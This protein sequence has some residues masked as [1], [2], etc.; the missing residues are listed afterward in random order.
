[1]RVVALVTR[2]KDLNRPA[3]AFTALP[4]NLPVKSVKVGDYE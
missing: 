2:T 1:M 4:L 3:E